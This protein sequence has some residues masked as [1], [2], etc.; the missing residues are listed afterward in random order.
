MDAAM[1]QR[2]ADDAPVSYTVPEDK[3]KHSDQQL[4]RRGRNMVLVIL[5]YVVIV[6]VVFAWFQVGRTHTKLLVVSVAGL[7]HDYLGKVASRDTPFFTHFL[8]Q[9]AHAEYLSPAFGAGGE[10][11]RATIFTGQHPSQHGVIGN[12]FMDRQRGEMMVNG[13]AAHSADDPDWWNG[14]IPI[15]NSAVKQWRKAAVINVHGG[16][17][18]FDG[19][20]T[21]HCQAPDPGAAGATSGDDHFGENLSRALEMLLDHDYTMA[22]VHTDVL[23]KAAQRRGADSREVLDELATLDARLQQMDQLLMDRQMREQLN[24]V[25]VSDGGLKNTDEMKEESIDRYMPPE[26]ISATIIGN[27]AV[28]LVYADSTNTDLVYGVLSNM[29][30]ARAFRR[31]EIP[32]QYHFD[33]QQRAPDVLVVADTNTYIENTEPLH[34]AAAGG[35]DDTEGN[36]PEMRGVLMGRGPGFM[37]GALGGPVQAVDVYTLLATLLDV[38]SEVHSGDP[39]VTSGLVEW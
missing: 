17:V 6:C 29:P 12:H 11:T 27:G 38:T 24:I 5:L 25:I 15:W 22:V 35:Y 39:A 26:G 16:C 33:H 19:Y 31:H 36:V 20:T 30:G 28:I 2:R 10:A 23:F 21:T 37:K 7:R 8:R 1:R 34:V 14:A 18:P 13:P 9:G 32:P 4:T 3:D